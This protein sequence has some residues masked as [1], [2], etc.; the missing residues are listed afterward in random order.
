MRTLWKAPGVAACL[1]L[2]ACG[3]AKKTEGA[4]AG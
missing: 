2:A 4:A 3:A 1:A